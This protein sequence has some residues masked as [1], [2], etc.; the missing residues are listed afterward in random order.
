[1]IKVFIVKRNMSNI[2]KHS[3]NSDSNSLKLGNFYINTGYVGPNGMSY[4]G[5]YPCVTPPNGGYC[6]YESKP[7]NGPSIMV[8]N[9]DEEL[10]NLTKGISGLELTTIGECLDY[11]ASQPDKTCINRDFEPVI[12]ESLLYFFDP[13][14]SPSNPMTSEFMYNLGS[15]NNVPKASLPSQPTISS[16]NGG[17]L[18]FNGVDEGFRVHIPETIL[19]VGN[20]ITVSAWLRIPETN[21]SAD[22]LWLGYDQITEEQLNFLYRFESWTPNT[23]S[24]V[25]NYTLNDGSKGLVHHEIENITLSSGWN[26]YTISLNIDGTYSIMVNDVEVKGGV[27]ENLSRWNVDVDACLVSGGV[28]FTLFDMGSLF[29]YNRGLN[30]D[31]ILHNF[32]S[33]KLKYNK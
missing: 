14:Y 25:A 31:E 28:D 8:V 2:I 17:I 9:N 13:S 1:M 22:I 5:Y 32:N 21:K 23:W 18:K 7:E 24:I 20:S 19:G 12:T 10:I 26:F 30:E 11:Y 27:I 6:I 29:I 33:Q 16:E 15:S 4:E 3:T